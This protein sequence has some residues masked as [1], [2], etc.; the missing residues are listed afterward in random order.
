MGLH[1]QLSSSQGERE[2]GQLEEKGRDLCQRPQIYPTERKTDKQTE[3]HSLQRH[4]QKLKSKKKTN[5]KKKQSRVD[6]IYFY[7]TVLGGEG[8]AS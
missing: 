7:Y 4:K 2:A 8:K 6:K 3:K 5:K 1:V